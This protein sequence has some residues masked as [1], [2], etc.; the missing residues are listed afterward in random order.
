MSSF[1]SHISTE[2]D[3]NISYTS[4]LNNVSPIMIKGVTKLLKSFINSSSDFICTHFT[5][6]YLPEISI[7]DYLIRIIENTQIEESTLISSLIYIERLIFKTNIKI[8]NLDIHRL[9]L[10]SIVLSIKYNEDKIYPQ[11]YY[12]NIGG[13]DVEEL[14]ILESEFLS[15]IE[16]ELFIGENEFQELFKHFSLKQKETDFCEIDDEE[17]L[18]LEND[19]FET[20][21]EIII[22]F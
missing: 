22:Q 1:V 3:S 18:Q 17:F 8:T 11:S 4:L 20:E 6:P 12:A 9:L 21:E 7:E 15:A 2:I 5:A 13:V 10:T 14:N 16:F 19:D